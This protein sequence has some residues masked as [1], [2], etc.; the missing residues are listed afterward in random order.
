VLQLH[1]C[2]NACLPL[3]LLCGTGV[4]RYTVA[5]ARVKKSTGLSVF[6]L[7][8]YNT[9]ITLPFLVAM[10]VCPRDPHAL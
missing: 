9:V 2:E 1:V 5:I 3:L 7:L 4:T 8:Y 10:V 6:G